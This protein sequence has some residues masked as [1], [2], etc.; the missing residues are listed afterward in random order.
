MFVG[1]QIQHRD[2]ARKNALATPDAIA[3]DIART[4]ASIAGLTSL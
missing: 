4:I 2:G 1:R 3:M